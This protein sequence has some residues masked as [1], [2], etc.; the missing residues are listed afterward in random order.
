MRHPSDGTLRR[1][2]D[3]PAGVSTADRGHVA[4]CRRCLAELAGMRTDAGLVGAALG[5]PVCE[6]GGAVDVESAW[7][8]LVSAATAD[9][10]PVGVT[11]GR[12]RR[13]TASLRR[14]AAAAVAAAIVL[15]GAGAAAAGDW[16]QIFRTEEVAPLALGIQDLSALPDLSAY[17]QLELGDDPGLHRVPDRVT[18]AAQTGLRV[19]RVAAL[20]NGVSGEPV[21][22]V[23]PEVSATFT[24]SAERAEKAAESVGAS[25]E[26]PPPGLD[27]STIQ[28]VAGPGVASVWR[29]PTGAPALVVGRAK[30]PSAY[31]SGP[32]PFEATVDYLL[33]L[34]GLPDD[35]AASLR[36]FRV[37]RSRLPVPL[38]AEHVR[39]S[40]A[41]V[42]GARATVIETRDRSM[43]AVVWVDDGVMT[44]V[45]GPLSSEEVL[46]V[47]RGLG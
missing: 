2:L 30:A 41:D 38:P 28:M 22:E 26:P 16:F 45:G 32:V 19:P 24:F 14:P 11:T 1:M 3:E 23:G 12:R 20:P 47:A 39:T 43:S 10:A 36:T 4:A 29:H 44:L 17:G 25:L 46:D 5:A 37:G 8:H 15:V 21:L 31:S 9:A 33:S 35:V 7:T 34:P 27:G 42:A 13:S 18:A 6:P 40:A